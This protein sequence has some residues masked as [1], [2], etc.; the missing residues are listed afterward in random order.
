[1]TQAREGFLLTRHWRDTPQGTEVEFWLATDN[2]PLQVFLPPQESVAFIPSAQVSQAQRLLAG[3][4]QY[5]LTPLQLKDFHR[6]PV[7]GLYCRAHRQLMRYEKLLRDGGVTVYEA[8]VRP[9]ERFLMERFITAPVWVDGEPRGEQLTNA[10]LKPNP[11]YRPPLKWVSLDIE[12]TRNGE[13]YCIGLEG[14]GQRTVYMLGP[15]NGD[16]SGLDFTLEYVAS[17]P[18]LLEKLNAWFAQHDPRRDYRLE[19]RAV[20][21]ARAAKKR[22]TL[23]PA[24][25]ARA[26]QSTARMARARV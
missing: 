12:T 5:R 11:H 3:E 25:I 10:R 9:P 6:Q 22:G 7:H 20:R 13:L 21:P 4:N 19:R 16:A 26:R 15:E 8:D 17:R 2:G 23:S 1:M 14:C 18:Q 24:F